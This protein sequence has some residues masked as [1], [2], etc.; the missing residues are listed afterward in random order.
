MTINPE[1][2]GYSMQYHGGETHCPGCDLQNWNVGRMTAECNGCGTALPIP[3]SS[4]SS[5]II[6]TMGGSNEARTRR[7]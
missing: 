6:R 1:Q 4:E 2:R 5:T 7:L 3:F